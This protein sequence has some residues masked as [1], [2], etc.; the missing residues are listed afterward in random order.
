VWTAKSHVILLVP[1]VAQTLVISKE[2]NVSGMRNVRLAGKTLK[3][4]A[5]NVIVPCV[6]SKETRTNRDV[7]TAVNVLPPKLASVANP[8]PKLLP[9]K[10]TKVPM[11]SLTAASTAYLCE[12][13]VSLVLSSL[14][15]L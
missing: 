6:S 12:G 9:K 8:V 1:Q 13:M 10:L 2:E 3:P 5:A 4:V 14:C 7:P 15:V 11:E